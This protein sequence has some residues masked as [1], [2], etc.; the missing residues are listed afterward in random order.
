METFK[1]SGIR[2]FKSIY[3]KI[4]PICDKNNEEKLKS[5]FRFVLSHALYVFLGLNSDRTEDVCG[6]DAFL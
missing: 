5:T 3:P 1:R 4:L 6:W 2:E